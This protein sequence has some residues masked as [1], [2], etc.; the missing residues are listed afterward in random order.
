MLRILKNLRKKDLLYLAGAILFIAA[1][2]WL[3][4][5]MPDYMTEITQLVQTPG[6]E[7]RDVL[8]AGGK[9]L[10]CALGSLISAVV[11]ALLAARIAT[12]F[13]ADLRGNLFYK[14]MAF[15]KAEIQKFSTAS[16][17]TRTTNDVTQVQMLIIMGM[18]AIIKAPLMGTWAV[19]KIAGKNIE[20]TVATAI[21]VVCLLA[22]VI[23]AVSLMLPKFRQVQKMT[24]DLNRITRENLTGLRVIRAYN[25]EAYQQNKFDKANDALTG[26]HLYTGRVSAFMMPTIQMFMSGLSLAI[27]WIGA[28]LIN[29]AGMEDKIGLF[30]EMIVFSQYAIQVV[31]AFMLLVILFI[32]LPRASVSAKRI[33]EVLDTPISITDGK[34]T[35]EHSALTGEIEFKNVSFRYPDAE[36]DVIHNISFKAEKGETVAIIGATGSGKSTLV[37]L[38][39]RFYDATNGE[40]LIDGV[41][42]KN[43]TLH[44]LR[45]KIGYISQRAILFSGTV[46][47]NVVFGD[48]GRDLSQN[49]IDSVYTAQAADFVEKMEDGYDGAI[50]QSGANLS[51]GQKQ[52]LS[53]ARAI[54]RRPE[55]LLFDDSFSALDYKTDRLLR[56][57]LGEDCDKITKLIVAQRIGTIRDADRIIVLDEGKMVGYGKH[58]ELMKNCEVYRE[59]AYS[60]LSKEELA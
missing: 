16:L 49:F 47:S 59:I 21:T 46:R 35:G 15:S 4:L 28:A 56:R 40:V 8:I 50:A 26:A 33:L 12:D 23:V 51:G 41:N 14:V 24:D 6:N 19:I 42:V 29:S 36:A 57:K 7:M 45:N 20:W 9:M 44:A 58:D 54:C 10:A 5:K 31:M 3:D 53:I 13:G 39:P 22:T 1:Q 32:M 2:V 48:A 37:D 52:R 60:Q 18:Q 30:S 17:I 55:I 25:A 43:Y 38:I 34:N 11:V 27:Y